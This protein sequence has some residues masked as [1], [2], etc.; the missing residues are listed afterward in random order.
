MAMSA[1][2]CQLRISQ[3]ASDVREAGM[4]I[5]RPPAP[6]SPMALDK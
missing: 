2:G 3:L 1:S 4:R 6:G 5:L